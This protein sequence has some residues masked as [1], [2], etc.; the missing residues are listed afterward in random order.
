MNPGTDMNTAKGTNRSFMEYA[1]Q[2]GANVG[3]HVG[4]YSFVRH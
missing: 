1:V 2:G 4:N 3:F